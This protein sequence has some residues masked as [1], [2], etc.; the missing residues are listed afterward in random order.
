[1][2]TFFYKSDSYIF[3]FPLAEKDAPCKTKNEDTVPLMV[4]WN[5]IILDFNCCMIMLTLSRKY[6]QVIRC[7]LKY[8]YLLDVEVFTDHRCEV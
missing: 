3:M 6:V 5:L 2:V 7:P 1:M 8:I 4:I